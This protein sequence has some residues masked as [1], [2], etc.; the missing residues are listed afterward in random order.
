MRRRERPLAR[1]NEALTNLAWWLRAQ[2]QHSGLS[3]QEMA[4]RTA[5]S[6]STLSRAANAQSLPRQAV[7]EAYARACGADVARARRLW[8]QAHRDL[9][10]QSEPVGAPRPELADSFAELHKAMLAL[11][12]RAGNP[13]L[14]ELER[15]AGANGELPHSTLHRILNKVAVPHLR[16]VQ[17]FAR[18]C[19]EDE[20]A[21]E[22][23][24]AAWERAK[25]QCDRRAYEPVPL[26]A[27]RRPAL[28]SQ[29]E[30]ALVHNRV[31]DEWAIK[32]NRERLYMQ[33]SVSRSL[34]VETEGRD[35]WRV[36]A[37]AKL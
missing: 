22:V 5:F 25:F 31:V 34:H 33:R 2:R 19:G 24:T 3:Y 35:G 7:V 8:R 9:L 21:V 26:S 23:W 6:A 14:K 13:S 32:G 10:H 4:S 15:R 28:L 17:A 1:W 29:E 27:L 12:Q 36:T 20:A 16:H 11:R 18:A 37:R 30:A